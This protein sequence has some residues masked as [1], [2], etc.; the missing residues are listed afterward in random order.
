MRFAAIDLS[1]LPPPDIIEPLDV[2]GVLAELT[3]WFLQEWEQARLNDP[4]LPAYTAGSLNTSPVNRILRVVAYRETLLRARI[5]DSIRAVFL[6]SSWGTNLDH[7]GAFLGVE[8]LTVQP[9]TATTP[10]VLEGDDRF[11]RRIQLALEAFSTAGSWGAYMF[12]TLTA[13]PKIKDAAVYGP[14][15]E[16]VDPGQVGVYLLSSEADGTPSA[17][18]MGL[19]TDHLNHEDIRTLTDEVLINAATIVPYS[20]EVTLTVQRGP[21]PEVIR[22]EV[23]RRLTEYVTERHKIGQKVSRE[24]LIAQCYVT[25][26]VDIEMTTPVADIVPTATEAAYCSAAS[27]LLTYVD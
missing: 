24:V 10:A 14:E 26:V 23:G 2:E 21:D 20:I 25:G 27:V 19:V 9:A 8:R 16:I 1:R 12:H 22:T 6:A 4:T 7:L 3:P 13:S 11:R 15:T 17:E 5:N 18:I